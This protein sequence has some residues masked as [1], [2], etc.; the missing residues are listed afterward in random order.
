MENLN[1]FDVKPEKEVKKPA[2]K[3]AKAP[4]APKFSNE[5][6]EMLAKYEKMHKDILR[7]KLQECIELKDYLEVKLANFERLKQR[8]MKRVESEIPKDVAKNQAAV[9]IEGSRVYSSEIENLKSIIGK[10]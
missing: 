1:E 6:K 3:P 9:I 4:E 8:N 5:E 10:L 7:D 2:K